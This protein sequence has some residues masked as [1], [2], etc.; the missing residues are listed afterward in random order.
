MTRHLTWVC[1][2]CG[3]RWECTD[4]TCE[5]VHEAERREEQRRL[6]IAKLENLSPAERRARVWALHEARGIERARG[7]G[8]L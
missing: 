2:F 6:V 5:C 3:E 8:R 7:E 1:E 4:F